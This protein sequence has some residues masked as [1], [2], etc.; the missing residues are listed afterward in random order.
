VMGLLFFVKRESYF[1]GLY[2]GW[3]QKW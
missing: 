1:E 3:M 2:F